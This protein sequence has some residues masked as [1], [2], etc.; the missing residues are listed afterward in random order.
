MVRK[1]HDVKIVRKRNEKI[2][3]SFL[4]ALNFVSYLHYFGAN[5]SQTVLNRTKL[6][7]IRKATFQ[8]SAIKKRKKCDKALLP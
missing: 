5:M 7:A 4:F 3:N 6:N 2:V 1:R 8:N